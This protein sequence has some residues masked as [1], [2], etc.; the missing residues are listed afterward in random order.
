MAHNNHIKRSFEAQ[1]NIVK[2]SIIWGRGWP[3]RL[4]TLT[5]WSLGSRLQS[6]RVISSPSRNLRTEAF[7]SSMLL[8]SIS[9]G[10]GEHRYSSNFCKV[11]SS[12][13][14]NAIC[15]QQKTTSFKLFAIHRMWTLK[16]KSKAHQTLTI[17]GGPQCGSLPSKQ[18]CV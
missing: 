16:K 15:R 8:W 13:L 5:M 10:R 11:F 2:F 7:T 4:V 9:S 14:S 1:N 3:V 12:P 18:F 6:A 17:S